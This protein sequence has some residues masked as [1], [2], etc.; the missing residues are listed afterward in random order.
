MFSNVEL[1]GNPTPPPRPRST[2]Y[3]FLETGAHRFRR[4]HRGLYVSP[5]RFEAPNWTRDGKSFFFNRDGRILRLPA[6]RQKA[7]NHRHRLRQSAAITITEFR[8]TARCW[9]SATNRRKITSHWFIWCPMNGGTPR[10]ITKNS[11]SYWHGWSPDGKTLA[12][13]GQRNGD[14]DIYTIPVEGGEETRLTTAKGLDDGP[15]YSPDGQVHLFQLR[16]HRS[17][18]DLAHEAGRQ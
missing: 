15:E 9:L 4:P 16:A 2:L 11:P 14:F 8:R 7:R 6:G 5:G 3:S 10:R 13:V 1:A 18:A 12:F 17:H